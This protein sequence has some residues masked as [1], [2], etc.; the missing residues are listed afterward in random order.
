M[1][2]Y[3]QSMKSFDRVG[4]EDLMD[5]IL[6]GQLETEEAKIK[7]TQTGEEGPYQMRQK[8]MTNIQFSSVL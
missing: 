3:Q 4:E 5:V 6:K 1:M 8:K 2:Y 7:I